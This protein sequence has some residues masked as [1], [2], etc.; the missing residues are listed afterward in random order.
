MKLG[1]LLLATS[2]GV[3]PG[4]AHAAD[5]V[6]G[7]APIDY[8]GVCKADGS[9]F[10][11]IPGTQTCLSIGGYLEFN[12]W[13]YD[14]K[15]VENIYGFGINDKATPDA[16][17]NF[18]VA[19]LYDDYKSNWGFSEETKVLLNSKAPSDLGT[20]E[21]YARF[22]VN[23]DGTTLA[24]D[25]RL[26]TLD[27]AYGS[28]GPI[29]FGYTDSIFAWQDAGLSLDGNI[30]A[31]PIVDQLQ[32]SHTMGPWKVAFALEDPR[33]YFDTAK[34][35]TGDYPNLAFAA[36]G[37]WQNAFVQA[38]LGVTDRTSGIG[39]GAQLSGQLGSGT[40]PQIQLNLAYADNAPAYV[41]GTNCSGVCGN[42]GSWWSAMVSG[43]V[44]LSKTLSLNST[45]SY[46][47]GPST[48]EWEAA[49]GTGW[50]PTGSSLLSLEVL[51][52]DDDGADS[53]GVHGQLKT[54][55]GND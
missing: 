1:T 48:Y 28:I 22:V 8:V 6:V 34:N 10:F 42:E 20:I 14:E 36:S 13:I 32:L 24:N 44:N 18:D 21:T 41:G 30:N 26:V 17:G 15:S 29:L 33:D 5:L 49:V 3:A 9:G 54:S 37:T 47:D 53:F 51:Y 7:V 38:A 11:L 31:D 35:A 55:F 52:T 50:A 45:V 25:K 19:P 23:S 40:N 43:Q 39:W 2:A 16:Y 4:F 27:K 46:L 12:A